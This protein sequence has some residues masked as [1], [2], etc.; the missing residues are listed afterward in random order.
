MR[1]FLITS[2]TGVFERFDPPIRARAWSRKVTD[3][4]NKIMRKD[5]KTQGDNSGGP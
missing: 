4:S 2:F 1:W 3:F 5:K